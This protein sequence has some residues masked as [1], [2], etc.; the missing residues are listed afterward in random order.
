MGSLEHLLEVQGH[1]TALDQ[2]RHRRASLPERAQLAEVADELA[3]LGLR[4]TALEA[5]LADLDRQQR[6]REDALAQL[7][8][9]MATVQSQLYSGAV[10]APRELKALQDEADVL[11]RRRSH[12]EDEVLEVLTD[13]EP[14]DAELAELAAHRIELD[15][16]AA[17]LRVVIVESEVD[18]DVQIDEQH[19]A[20]A[21]VSAR[22][23]DELLAHY[24]KLR[25]ALGGIGVALLANG[26]CGGCHL[27]LPATELDALRKLADDGIAHCEQCGRI[28]VRPQPASE[29]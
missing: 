27:S 4:T 7:E 15:S 13:R 8:S 17:A 11:Q 5:R 16:A 21:A 18:L 25:S 29:G 26:R 23:D 10:T 1:D 6:H 20:R 9:K 3:D 22:V 14:L 2:L 19:K 28:L 12:A 24:E